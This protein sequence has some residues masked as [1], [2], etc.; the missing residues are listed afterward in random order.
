MPARSGMR[1]RTTKM[2]LDQYI[3]LY[4]PTK[5]ADGRDLVAWKRFSVL[6]KIKQ[7][8]CDHFGGYTAYEAE[9][10]WKSGKTYVYE[11][12]TVIQSFYRGPGAEA[13]QFVKVLAGYV[14]KKLAQEAVTVEQNGGISFI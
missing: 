8:M 4:I 5:G 13:L 1:G 10:G 9:G 6:K 2:D 14:K 12:I 11:D 7:E 3:S